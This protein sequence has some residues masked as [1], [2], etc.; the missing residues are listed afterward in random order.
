MHLAEAVAVLVA[1]IL[2][3]AMADRLVPVAPG[4]QARVDVVF[5]GVDQAVRGNGRRD[6]R[7]DRLL[8][9]VGEHAER[10]LTAALDQTEDGGLVLLQCAPSRRPRQPAVSARPPLFA[11]A[12]GWPLCPATT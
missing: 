10:E 9:H 6:H 5:V 11:T 1:G 7:L 2:T 3:A 4:R 12:A 8:L